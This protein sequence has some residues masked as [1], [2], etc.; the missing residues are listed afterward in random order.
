MSP[1][2]WSHTDTHICKRLRLRI[3]E[4]LKNSL[5]Q[6]STSPFASPV[7]LVKKKKTVGRHY[8]CFHLE[9]VRLWSSG[10]PF[11]LQGDSG[12]EK[13]KADGR[14]IEPLLE[15]KATKK[16]FSSFSVLFNRLGVL[17][18]GWMRSLGWNRMRRML[19]TKR[20]GRLLWCMERNA[21]NERSQDR[22][23]TL[24]M[25]GRLLTR[26]IMLCW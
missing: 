11:L 1:N 6:P 14:G 25:G 16:T 19:G 23:R 2:I 7:L 5:I 8:Q 4:L 20:R 10:F 21:W 17:S 18:D 26:S 3:E 22:R 15:T 24:E 9:E 13:K 12:C